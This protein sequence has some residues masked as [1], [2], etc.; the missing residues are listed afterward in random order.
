M[1]NACL[2]HILAAIDAANSA[3]PKSED[4]APAARLY[5]ERM[6]A[7]L[8][9]FRPDASDL[10]KIAA[11]GQHIERWSL[12][13]DAYPAGKAGYYAWRNA[14]KKMHAERV[15]ALMEEA[16]YSAEQI[17]ATQA[18][19]RKDDLRANADAQTVE[20]VASLVFLKHYGVDFASDRTP[21]QL[22][23]I[24]AKTMRKMSPQAIA[25]AGKIGMPDA[26]AALAGEAAKKLGA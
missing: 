1:S 10:V 17:A 2:A 9:L 24:L 14:A 23:D 20:D 5:G 7:M 11:R 6:S 15:G 25:F 12:P 22:I 13:R 8:A 19:V 21:E 18:M 3:D 4:G 26:V 16:G